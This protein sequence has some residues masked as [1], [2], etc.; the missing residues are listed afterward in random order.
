MWLLLT[1]EI[2]TK[3]QCDGLTA[4][5][6]ERSSLPA[7]ATQLLD[8]LP[9]TMHP[10]TQFSLGLQAYRCGV[11]YTSLILRV[12]E[13]YRVDGVKATHIYATDA[14]HN[15]STASMRLVPDTR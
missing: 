6:F 11:L 13:P 9:K 12:C 14:N 1:G 2:P 7:H 5:L 8:S 3:E 4:E 10:M 15:A